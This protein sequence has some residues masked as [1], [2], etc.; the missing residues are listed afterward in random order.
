MDF[1]ERMF[2]LPLSLFVLTSTLNAESVRA[3]VVD[4]A[5]VPDS[6]TPPVPLPDSS[7]QPDFLDRPQPPSQ[8]PLEPVTPTP[9]PPPEELLEPSPAIPPTPEA[10]PGITPDTMT[11]ERFEFEGNTA[12][13]DEEL[14]EV[15]AQFTKRPIS[16]AELLQ[17]RSAVSKLYLD[18]GY[19]TT[20][21]FIPAD[22]TIEGGVVKIQ[23]V[24]G[25]L[26]EIIVTGTRRL[27]SGYV[28]SRLAIA[29]RKPLNQQR[30]L[31]GLQ[32]LQLNPLIENLSAELS[33]G[34]EPGTSVLEVRV[35]EA[36]TFNV[37]VAADNNRNP[38][39]G[40][41]QRRVQVNQANL[42]GLGDSLSVGY[43][44]TDGSN[45]V[46][47]S[48][49]LPINPRNGTLSFNYG[50]TSSDVI[51]SPF[52][53]LNIDASSRYY[54]LTLRQ[55]I[56]QSPTREFALGL[57]ASRQES[58]VTFLEGVFGSPAVPFTDSPGADAQGRTRI[59]AIRFFQEW[60]ERNSREVIA[61]RSQF[62]VG[63]GA[64]DATINEE[65]PDSRFFSWRGQAQWVRRLA[66]DTF[67]LV[68]GDV[69]LADR[70]LVPL[71]QIG[72]GGQE[73]V[74]G[75]RQDIFLADNGAY[76]S[77]EV[78]VPIVR[79][80]EW[81][82]L[83]QV[84]P[85]VD[86]GAAWNNSDETELDSNFLASVGLGLQM[87]LG[88]RVSARLD[89]GIPLVSVSSSER[90]LQEDGFYFSIVTTFF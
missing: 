8:E 62:S 22:Q 50:N 9:L 25:G 82:A 77:A 80:R 24:E 44:N 87:R 54:E 53:E 5:Q 90:T 49:T 11:V 31:E 48:Y 38:S 63:V 7:L 36:D 23:V 12:L 6:V 72:L 19:I 71:E 70:S 89:Y 16:F 42:L 17:A 75:Y 14:A 83:V 55:P 52:D 85:F 10:V 47:V 26:E 18:R 40:S 33:A 2:L 76:A 35:T 60:I 58:K 68:R 29:A 67:L 51:E 78:R 73:T 61:A 28:R 84:A 32:L 65:A 30:L 4:A 13:S 88:D 57:T 39:V 37:Q 20:G 56:V 74:R 27:N 21:A 69:Q 43:R 15:T 46:Q 79:I 3:Q 41:F 1:S 64:F 34:T 81:D 86:F 66:E 59:S 45:G